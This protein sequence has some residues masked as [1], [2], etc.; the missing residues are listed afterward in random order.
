MAAGACT[1]LPDCVTSHSGPGSP[2][3]NAPGPVEPSRTFLIDTDTASDD[4]VAL[5]MALRNPAIRV[6]AITVVAGNV[7]VD[8][9]VQNALYTC[10]L[11]QKPTP[12]YRGAEA[13]LVRPYHDAEFVHGHD[14]MGDIGLPLQGRSATPGH[15]VPV[16]L[17]CIRRHAG[18]ITLVTLGPL[19]NLALAL[20]QEPAIAKLVNRYV[21]MGGIGYGPGNITPVAEYNIWADPDAAEIVFR[22]G[23][24]IEMVGWDISV[25]AAVLDPIEAG[26]LRAIGTP[27]ARFCVDIQKKLA[28]FNIEKGGLSGFDLPDPI[29]MAVALDATV[30]TKAERAYVE[31]ETQGDR[32]LGQTIVDHLKVTGKDAN[33]SIVRE[34][35]RERFLRILYDA[36]RS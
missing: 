14:G 21:M 3:D 33:T 10:E 23:L 7:N 26:R 24:P 30:A 36:V 12:V 15:A 25:Q 5:V 27:L 18:E 17:D 28:E 2:G 19:T 8:K 29:A 4:A 20:K 16:I 13:P 1:L 32:S 6:E 22:S 31:V 34:A 9:G 11:C 35:S